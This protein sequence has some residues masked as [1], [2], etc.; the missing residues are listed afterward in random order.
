MLTADKWNVM[1]PVVKAEVVDRRRA[2]SVPGGEQV[3]KAFE[4]D[5]IQVV[6]VSTKEKRLDQRIRAQSRLHAGEGEALASSRGLRLIVDDKEAR[7]H[8]ET[9]NLDYVGTAAVLLEAFLE[10]HLNFEE[11]EDAVNDLSRT[12]WI[13]PAVVAEILKR[14]REAK[15]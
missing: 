14:A 6:R 3:E 7:A 1:R 12:M 13:S 9:M 8:A 4:D 5:W 15:K 10:G 11:I 2:I